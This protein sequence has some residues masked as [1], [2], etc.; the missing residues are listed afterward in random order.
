MCGFPLFLSPQRLQPIHRHRFHCSVE[1]AAR[2]HV[3]SDSYPTTLPVILSV[4]NNSISH[5]L[6]IGVEVTLC[7]IKIAHLNG[8][9]V[10]A[11]SHACC[12]VSATR[13]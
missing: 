2:T 12:L 6:G 7:T 9:R 13:G 5:P 8:S 1:R 11:T 3:A 10:T 4:S